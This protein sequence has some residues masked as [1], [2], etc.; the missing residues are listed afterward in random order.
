MS[1]EE[2]PTSSTGER[3]TAVSSP[4][5]PFSS[6][7]TSLPP[8]LLAT[9]LDGDGLADLVLLEEEGLALL[10]ASDDLGLLGIPVSGLSGAR[11]MAVADQDGDGAPDYLFGRS[12]AGV[13][14]YLKPGRSSPT[15]P[16]LVIDTRNA[17]S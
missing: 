5:S 4:Q 7:P 13:P 16:S 17:F 10:Y 1:S 8:M 12:R 3:T 9:D 15:A 14:V 2:P 6:G 11:V